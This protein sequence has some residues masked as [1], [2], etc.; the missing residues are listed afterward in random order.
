MAQ[1]HVF[2]RPGTILVHGTVEWVDRASARHWTVITCTGIDDAIVTL[3]QSRP[4]LIVIDACHAR[5]TCIERIHQHWA[6]PL[7]ALVDGADTAHRVALLDA[8]ATLCLPTDV[9]PDHAITRLAALMR[10]SERLARKTPAGTAIGGA[11]FDRARR[12][13]SRDGVSVKLSQTEA[14]LLGLLVDRAGEV[15]SRSY[16]YERIWSTEPGNSRALDQRVTRLRARLAPVL[17]D[18]IVSSYGQGYALRVPQE[19]PPPTP[20][21]RRTMRGLPVSVRNA[22]DRQPRSRRAVG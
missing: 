18:A 20:I 10:T 13:V 5:V 15:L 2:W 12:V 7:V 3:K 11:R 1:S 22:L 17:P 4:A 14:E 21:V 16:L 6:G 19:P 8:G 9:P